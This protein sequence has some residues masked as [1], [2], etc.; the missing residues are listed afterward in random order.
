MIFLLLELG[1]DN[2]IIFCFDHQAISVC[3]LFFFFI[4]FFF[5]FSQCNLWNISVFCHFQVHNYHCLHKILNS[6]SNLFHLTGRKSLPFCSLGSMLYKWCW[7]ICSCRFS[8]YFMSSWMLSA[9]FD[10]FCYVKWIILIINY[11]VGSMQS[12]KT[13]QCHY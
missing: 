10:C 1:V 7:V 9:L 5:H 11:E 12:V 3:I 8:C 13:Q 4:I 2:F 6:F